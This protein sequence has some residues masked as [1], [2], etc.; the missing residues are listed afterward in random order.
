MTFNRT[1]LVAAYNEPDGK[2]IIDIGVPLNQDEMVSFD[3][4]ATHEHKRIALALEH[5][6]DE[7]AVR[8]VRGIPGMSAKV[9][10][11]DNYNSIEIEIIPDIMELLG[12][13]VEVIG[14]RDSIKMKGR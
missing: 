6:D 14:Y 9:V 5:V 1:E 2:G 10:K 3:L 11:G 13:S 8:I 4:M 12:S 7:P